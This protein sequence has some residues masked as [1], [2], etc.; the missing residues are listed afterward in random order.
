MGTHR[1]SFTYIN[2]AINQLK[3]GIIGDPHYARTWYANNRGP[4]GFGKNVPVPS[5]LDFELWQGPAPRRPYRDNLVHYNW[6]WFWHWGTGEL[7][8]NGTHRI[9]LA[10]WGLGVDYPLTVSS[11]GGRYAYKD[12]WETPDTQITV[13][14]FP[15]NKT[16]LWEGKSCNIRSM[17]SPGALISFH[18]EQGTL[19]LTGNGYIVYDNDNKEVKR[20]T[21]GDE[22]TTID[23][24]GPGVDMSASHTHNF[25]EA[26]RKGTVPSADYKEVN[27]STLLCQLGNIAHRVG[28]TIRC[29]PLNGKIIGDPEAMRFWRRDYEPGWEPGAG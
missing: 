16:I 4:I 13:Y 14:D 7:L 26:I 17:E 19:V 10:R 28:R 8:N 6:H 27:K 9:D 29:N 3:S 11:H 2:E 21:E 22:V 25:A 5:N 20:F 12:D 1:R 24:T 15:E 23:L 18:S